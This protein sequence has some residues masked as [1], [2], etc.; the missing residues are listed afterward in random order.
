MR[1]GNKK[2]LIIL[3]I[4]LLLITAL[5]S[6]YFCTKSEKDTETGFEA[7]SNLVCPQNVDPVCGEDGKTYVNKC[8]AAL[9]E[10][11]IVCEKEC[12]CDISDIPDPAINPMAFLVPSEGAFSVGQEIDLDMNATPTVNEANAVAVDLELENLQVVSYTPPSDLEFD[13]VPDCD[14]GEFFKDNRVCFSYAQ[15]TPLEDYQDLGVLRVTFIDEGEAI[16]TRTSEHLYSN[17]S[18]EVNTDYELAAKYDVKKA[19]IEFGCGPMDVDG[20]GRYKINDLAVLVGMFK[21][22]CAIG[23]T[24]YGEC[25]AKD[26]DEDGKIKIGD[27]VYLIGRYKTDTCTTER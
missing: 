23:E 5:T 3:T 8:Y 11:K 15:T 25:G 16:V 27:I 22:D 4:V 17:S 14:G 9:E 20:D 24:N 10:V 21:R 19:D 18:G 12:P 13:I 26:I 2:Y 1:S 6:M 7:V